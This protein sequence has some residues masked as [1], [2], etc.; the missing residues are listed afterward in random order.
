MLIKFKNN[1]VRRSYVE[2]GLINNYTENKPLGYPE[3]WIASVI[4]AFNPGFPQVENE[5]LSRFDDGTF[6]KDYILSKPECLGR[7]KNIGILVKF[8]DA[9]ERLVIQCHPNDDFAQKYFDSPVGKTECWYI[10]DNQPDAYVYLGFNKSADKNKW[11]DA[12][13]SQDKESML[14]M[15]HKIKVEKGDCVFVGGGMPHAIGE[16]CFLLELQQPTD[17]MVIPERRTLSGREL[18]E[19]KLHGGLGF[20]RMFDCFDYRT[21]EKNEIIETCFMKTKKAENKIINV[22]DERFTDKFKLQQLFITDDFVYENGNEY[23]VLVITEGDGYLTDGLNKFK[24]K[25]GDKFFVDANSR[26]DFNT[27]NMI[28]ACICKQ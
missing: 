24:I 25:K 1:R 16:G 5:G 10:I 19:R 28:A 15:L 27:E 2:S 14:S 3:D 17:L 4:T 18:D 26:L 7:H 12:F 11:V 9:G 6:F 23:N 20:E 8:L 21:Y 22:I 13:N